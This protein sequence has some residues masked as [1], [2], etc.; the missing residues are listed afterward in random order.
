MLGTFAPLLLGAVA[1]SLVY[2]WKGRWGARIAALVVTV[3]LS[4]PTIWT[5]VSMLQNNRL[6]RFFLLILGTEA[7]MAIIW[8]IL[9]LI[10]LSVGNRLH[11]Q[12]SRKI[13]IKTFD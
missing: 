8:L 9:V 2:W 4:L 1:V 13:D 10:A 3:I 5:V 7:P 11:N 12:A 6:G